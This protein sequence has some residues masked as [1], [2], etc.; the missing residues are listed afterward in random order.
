MSDEET[1]SSTL[2]RDVARRAWRTITETGAATREAARLL[3]VGLREYLDIFS[4][5]Y[6]ADDGGGGT[7]KLVLGAN[8]EGKTHLLYCLRERALAAGHVVAL[9]DAK[10]AGA[11]Q[12]PLVFAQ[13]VLQ[14][15]ETPEL[16]A[17]GEVVE[18]DE[19]SLLRLLRVA[20]D[21]RRAAIAANGL[22]PADL[23]NEWAEGLRAKN[24][25][26]HGFAQ[27]LGDAVN[28]IAMSD[29]DRSLSAIERL[30][31]AKAK[32]TKDAQHTD[33][34]NLLRSAAKLPRE[35]GFRPLVLLV[36]EAETAVE[37]AGSAK[38]RAFNTFLRFLNDHVAH[39]DKTPAIVVV[40]C[41]DGLWPAQ[42][43]EY[44]ALKQRFSD[45]GYD[46]LDARGRLT[47]Q[48]LPNRNKLWVR[49]VFRGIEAEYEELGVAIIGLAAQAIGGVDE[50]TQQANSKQLGRV[51]SSGMVDRFVKRNFV[52][53]LAQTIQDQV[54]EGHQ[55]VLT[56]A[57]ARACFDRAVQAIQKVDSAA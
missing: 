11:A 27:A 35:M 18:S 25:Y 46:S 10:S 51:A 5:K 17:S 15:V 12:S 49:E 39:D 41:T 42:F 20:V 19:N 34:A 24:L 21:R 47:A 56:D 8:G 29:M 43:N 3:Q 28:A 38:R 32:L 33:G 37:K 14:N 7:F 22:D 1:A 31:F 44:S 26:P 16:T 2:K 55:R 30:T 13:Q 45:P 4:R 53:A 57:D 9:V 6:L 23:L 54:D 48:T 40:A 36:D 50:G 52:K